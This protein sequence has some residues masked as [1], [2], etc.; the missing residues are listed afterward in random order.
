[1]RT[2]GQW[3]EMIQGLLTLEQVAKRG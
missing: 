3:Q 2:Q 1:V